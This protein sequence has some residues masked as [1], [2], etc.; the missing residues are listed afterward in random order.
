MHYPE[1]IKKAVEA[2]INELEK[3]YPD[4]KIKKYEENDIL[5]TFSERMEFGVYLELIRAEH[6]H[7]KTIEEL[8]SREPFYY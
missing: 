3:V 2:L 7:L 6:I 8:L 1:P 5:T 4:I